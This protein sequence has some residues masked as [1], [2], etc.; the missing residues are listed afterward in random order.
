MDTSVLEKIS[1]WKAFTPCWLS[2][3]VI[4]GIVNV[5]LLL[6]DRVTLRDLS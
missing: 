6:V 5:D 1:F 2:L 4:D 3:V